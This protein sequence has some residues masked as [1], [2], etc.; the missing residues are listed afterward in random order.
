MTSSNGNIFRVASSLCGKFS[1]HRWMSLI[2][3]S[4]MERH[5]SDLRRHL[6]H[7]DVAHRWVISSPLSI[8][9]QVLLQ[10]KL[11]GYR[12]AYLQNCS[13]KFRSSR[14]LSLYSFL[15]LS[16]LL[17]FFRLVCYCTMWLYFSQ[18]ITLDL[19]R[20]TVNWCRVV[21]DDSSTWWVPSLFVFIFYS[22]FSEVTCNL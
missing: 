20:V 18:G 7:C 1:R 6:T 22:C 11:P 8:A 12:F 17:T 19:L 3:V 2:K 14:L 4:H 5:A 16:F 10:E 15:S 13:S 9:L 21:S